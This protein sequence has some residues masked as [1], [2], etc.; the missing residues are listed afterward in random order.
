M[1][2]KA[3]NIMKNINHIYIISCTYNFAFDDFW[4]TQINII[5]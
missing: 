1:Y 2:F 3:V 4:M 5:Q